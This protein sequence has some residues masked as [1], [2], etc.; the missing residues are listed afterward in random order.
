[1]VEDTVRNQLLNLDKTFLELCFACRIGDVENAD[2]LISTGVNVNGV[3]EF[4]NSPLFLASLCGHEEVVKLLLR[5]GSVCDRDRYEGARCIYGALT[6]SIRNILLKYDISK[7]VDIKQP[8]ASHLSSLVNDGAMLDFDFEFIFDDDFRLPVHKFMLAA[9]SSYFKR[10][11]NG[12]WAQLKYKRMPKS[13]DAEAFSLMLKFIYLVPVLHELK[14][15]QLKYISLLSVKLGFADLLLYLDRTNHVSDPSERA[16]L[17]NDYQH[18]FNI[19]ARG[20]LEAYVRENIFENK[21]SFSDGEDTHLDWQHLRE[22]PPFG[23]LVLRFV[24]S[25]GEQHAYVCH[26]SI[27]IRSNFFKLMFSSSFQEATSEIPVIS[28]PANKL[29]VAEVVLS[30]LYYDCTDIPWEIAIDV[31][32]I[33]DF[34]LTDR[35]KTMAAVT[36]TQSQE[37]LTKYSI[38]DVLDVAWSCSVERLEHYAAKHIANDI[39]YYITDPLLTDAIMQSSR[40]IKSRQDTDTIELVDDIRF[41]LLQKYD[42]QADILVLLDTED[43]IDFLKKSGLLEYKDDIEMLDKLLNEIGFDV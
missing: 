38:F 39:E 40:R 31:L 8:F 37:F 1:M 4:D 17:M 42:L 18:K 14:R 22:Q 33:S 7:A 35:L 12:R 20:Q 36:I 11:F 2:R 25:E 13:S 29:S 41:Y 5:R 24:T 15:E 21:L 16:S 3:D 26:K 9:R 23:D 28:L 27:L 30:Y 19:Y 34:L 6:D 32:K 10:K 43:D